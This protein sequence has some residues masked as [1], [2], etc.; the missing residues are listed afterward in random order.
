MYEVTD[1]KLGKQYVLGLSTSQ[2]CVEWPSPD[3]DNV[4]NI[5]ACMYIYIISSEKPC[6]K[7]N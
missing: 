7:S 1:N 5:D 4:L 2:H 3:S 6:D